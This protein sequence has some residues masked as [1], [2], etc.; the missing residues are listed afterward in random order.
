MNIVYHRS[1][2]RNDSLMSAH[3]MLR[4]GNVTARVLKP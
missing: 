1:F 3:E 4:A 2:F